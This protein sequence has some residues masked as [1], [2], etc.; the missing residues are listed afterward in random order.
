MFRK[1]RGDGGV[2]LTELSVALFVSSIVVA[3]AVTWA[4]ATLNQDRANQ[5]ASAT[6][7]ELRYAKSQL[8]RELRFA[9]DVYAPSPGDDYIE[10]WLDDGDDVLTAGAGEVIRYE[11]MPDGTFVRSTDDIA[12]PTKL[13]A[14]GLQAFESSFTVTGSTVDIVLT[15]DFDPTDSYKA[16]SLE[17]SITARSK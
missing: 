14:T 7:D 17:T 11:I 2:S 8:M 1:L 3:G 10:F 4:V 9:S 16:R 6:I 5:D 13:I 15:I 12:A